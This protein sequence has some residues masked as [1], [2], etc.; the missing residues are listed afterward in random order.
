MKKSASGESKHE[1]IGIIEKVHFFYERGVLMCEVN[2]FDP[3]FKDQI[4]ARPGGERV[5][6]CFLC[7]TCTAGCPVSSIDNAFNPR[8]IMS[9]IL[10]G[11]KTEVLSSREIWQCLQCHTCVAHC[12]QDVRF[13][14]VVRVIR[15]MMVEEGYA[16][17]EWPEKIERLD[18]DLKQSR[19]E[20]I[21]QITEH[22]T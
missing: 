17:A 14:D 16:P 18:A 21:R 10:L 20:K 4:A 7:G 22:E 3:D 9:R 15:R 19:M 1:G 2:S 11:M 12:P 5:K 6:N 13:A 8:G